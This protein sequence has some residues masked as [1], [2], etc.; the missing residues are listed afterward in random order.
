MTPYLALIANDLRLALRERAVIFFNYLFPLAF[1]FG[2]G[3]MLHAERSVGLATLVVTSVL[4]I[5]VLGN[6]LFGAG[7]RTVIDREAGILRRFKVAPIS[8]LPV[9]TASLVTGWLLYVPNLLMMI[10]LAHAIWR[11]PLPARPISLFMFL[12]VAVITFRAIGLI[13]AA[14]ANSTAESNILVQLCYMPMMFLSGATIPIAVLPPWAQTVAG[15]LPAFYLVNGIQGILQREESLAANLVPLAALLVTLVVSTFVAKQLFRW[16]KEQPIKPAAKAWVAAVMVPFVVLGL[17]EV[18]TKS[19]RTRTQGLYRDAMRQ[20]TFLIR[21]AGIFIG[22]GRVIESGGVLVRNGKIAEVYDGAVPDPASLNA[23]TVEGAGKTVLPGLIDVH[24]HLGS[25][26]GVYSDPKE[27]VSADAMPRALAQYLYSGVTAVK[28]AGDALDLSLEARNRVAVGERLGAEL[29]VSGPMFTAAG[30]HGT[31]YAQLLPSNLRMA[32]E[33]QIARTPKTADEARQQVVALKA[34]GVDGLKAI[35]E[36]GFAGGPLLERLDTTILK[37]IGDQAHAEHLPLVVHTATGRDVA[38]ALDAGAAG[39]EHGPRE[40]ISDELL[41]RI[42]ASGA[43][44]DPTLS[45]WDARAQL[46]EGRQDLLDRSLVQQAVAERVLIP[47]RAM[48]RERATRAG[49]ADRAM[50][51]LLAL[52]SENL[53]RAYDAGVTLVTGSD[54]GNPLVFHGPTIQHELQLWVAAGI[55]AS[56]A[57]QAATWN[58]ARLLGAE[59]RIGLVAKG[60][61]ANLLIVDGNP[62][63]DITT[64]ERISVVVFKGERVRRA[65]LFTEGQNAAP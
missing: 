43:A 29:F 2:L 49:D 7:I 33:A 24:V 64:T 40:R 21:G 15:F 9:L 26:G 53:K 65:T 20:S 38:D 22:D 18:R 27:Y 48:V 55:P 46:E 4:V 62:L 44:Y 35:L 13:I 3:G 41:R 54:A 39:I 51:R 60:H 50:R 12:S 36:T 25:P 31:E 45:V 14:V 47:T 30:G 56:A 6:G 37:A 42:K 11:M 10:G 58:A 57:L 61:D 1:F 8:P 34:A 19:Q 59:S 5:G 63:A 28:S 23:E 32:F 17:Q 52:E 16:E